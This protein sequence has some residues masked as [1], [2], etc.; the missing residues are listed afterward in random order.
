MVRQIQWQRRAGGFWTLFCILLVEIGHYMNLIIKKLK[1]KLKIKAGECRVNVRKMIL[2]SLPAPVQLVVRLSEMGKNLLSS[3]IFVKARERRV[4][5]RN[6]IVANL[7]A[8]VELV[9]RLPEIGKNLLSSSKFVKEL[10]LGML[11]QKK[12]ADDNHSIKDCKQDQL[13]DQNETLTLAEEDLKTTPLSAAKEDNDSIKDCEQDQLLDQDE[14]L[15]LAE[16]DNHSIKDCEQDQLLDQD[17]TLPLA[18]ED[19]KTTPLSASKE[20]LFKLRNRAL[21]RT[22]QFAGNILPKQKP[23]SDE[24]DQLMTKEQESPEIETAPLIQCTVN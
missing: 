7:P 9:A 24:V 14:T 18:E 23:D 19:L 22:Q 1:L 15:T 16:E 10:N 11:R 21:F 2:A 6:L 8:H 20:D 13:L 17:K 3:P 4:K 12:P 5:V